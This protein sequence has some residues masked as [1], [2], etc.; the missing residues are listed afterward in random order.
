VRYNTKFGDVRSPQLVDG[1]K[2]L[3]SCVDIDAFPEN[4]PISV[5]IDI[6]SAEIVRN[7]RLYFTPIDEG[8]ESS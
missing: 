8:K 6:D 4:N 5:S 3:P 2:E 1:Q 7:L